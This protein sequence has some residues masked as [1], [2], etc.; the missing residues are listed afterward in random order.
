MKELVK[1]NTFCWQAMVTVVLI[2]FVTKLIHANTIPAKH[3]ILLLDVK[4]P[5][6]RLLTTKLIQTILEA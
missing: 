2:I 1:N 5:Y 4:L 3:R 6:P